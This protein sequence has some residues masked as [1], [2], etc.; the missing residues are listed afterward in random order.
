ML[1]SSLPLASSLVEFLPAQSVSSGTY[2]MLGNIQQ[3]ITFR[4]AQT[5]R[6]LSH[7]T[8][9]V[10]GAFACVEGSG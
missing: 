10:V 1:I 8:I 7:L 3:H 6:P 9:R 5:W 2:R 4:A